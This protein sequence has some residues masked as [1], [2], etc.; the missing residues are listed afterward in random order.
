[1]LEN[2]YVQAKEADHT[3]Q[4]MTIIFIIVLGTITICSL[5]IYVVIERRKDASSKVQLVEI[6]KVEVLIS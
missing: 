3:M 1:M 6:T 4:D 2:K 5:V